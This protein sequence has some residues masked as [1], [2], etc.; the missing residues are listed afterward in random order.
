M[1]GKRRL[2]LNKSAQKQIIEESIRQK[3]Q[4]TA[5]E[6]SSLINFEKEQE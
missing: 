1:D 6:I 2:S 5:I 3:L 4:P